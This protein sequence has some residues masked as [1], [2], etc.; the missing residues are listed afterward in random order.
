MK[1]SPWIRPGS[2]RNN[3]AVVVNPEDLNEV[4]VSGKRCM[5]VPSN[6]NDEITM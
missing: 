3:S 2:E 5:A 6:S 1:F 4:V